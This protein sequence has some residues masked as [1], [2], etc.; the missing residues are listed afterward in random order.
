[1]PM[2]QLPTEQLRIVHAELERELQE[3]MTAQGN[4]MT[5]ALVLVGA[6]GL[7]LGLWDYSRPW[8]WFTSVGSA[9]AILAAIAGLLALWLWRSPAPVMTQAK[10]ATRLAADEYSVLYW[11]VDDL[12]KTITRRV[13][14]V[15]RKGRFITVGFTLMSAGWV[16][17]VLGMFFK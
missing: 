15:R 14:D 10:V 8:N 13:V 7:S 17:M 16:S 5:R 3:N 12:A 11:V 9:L 2:T 6:A 1:M 4:M